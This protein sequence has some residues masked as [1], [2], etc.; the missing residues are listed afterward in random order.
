MEDNQLVTAKVAADTLNTS[1]DIPENKLVTYGELLSMLEEMPKLNGYINS[2]YN[3][4]YKALIQ[5]DEYHFL[6]V[7]NKA[8]TEAYVR[9]GYG[10]VTLT[11]DTLGGYTAVPNV[12]GN[13]SVIVEHNGKNGV[14]CYRYAP[15]S[16]GGFERK[17]VAGRNDPSS[18]YTY[19]ITFNMNNDYDMSGYGYFYYVCIL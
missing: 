4:I 18:S 8:L 12:S 1:T 9:S 3:D 14:E 15:T 7:Q 2:S 13:E 11:S 10:A 19:M 16:N 17:K 5:K 6:L